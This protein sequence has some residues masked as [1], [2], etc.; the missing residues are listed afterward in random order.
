MRKQVFQYIL[1]MLQKN[2]QNKGWRPSSALC[3]AGAFAVEK[4]RLKLVYHEIK[5]RYVL[6]S[7]MKK[8]I[9][10]NSRR[11]FVSWLD[12]SSFIILREQSQTFTENKSFSIKS[13]CTSSELYYSVLNFS[14]V[15]SYGP[16][17]S[18]VIPQLWGYIL[19]QYF[20]ELLNC[21]KSSLVT[22]SRRVIKEK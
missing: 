2:S 9:S 10:K 12:K 22:A 6:V 8:S 1:N 17:S 7:S 16:H 18:E 14:S 3:G 4:G 11:I 13:Q 20:Y 21:A 5:A 19:A 15:A